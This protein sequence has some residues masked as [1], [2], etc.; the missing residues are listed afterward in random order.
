MKD[1]TIKVAVILIIAIIVGVVGYFLV[2]KFVLNKDDGNAGTNE[3]TT[4]TTT[5]KKTNDLTKFNGVYELNGAKLKLFAKNSESVLFF[6]EKDSF[7][8]D[9]DIEYSNGQLV[10]EFMD[11]KTTIKLD[12]NNV[13]IESNVENVESGTYTKNLD[14]DLDTV[15]K[16]HFGNKE[17]LNN[18]TNGKYTLDSGYL[19]V[20]QPKEDKVSLVGTLDDSSLMIDMTKEGNVYVSEVFETR[21]ELSFSGDS[22]HFVIHNDGVTDYDKTLKRSK[23]F[24][25]NDII[26]IFAPSYY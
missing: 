11:E 1:N 16:E 15:Y 17:L 25:A 4:N 8:S 6:Y 2:W 22:I 24:T 26:D 3:N 7:S 12:G 9:G 23:K 10:K 21:Y 19:N 18:D 5:E 14:Y 20:Y 13:V